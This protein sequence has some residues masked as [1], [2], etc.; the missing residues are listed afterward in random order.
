MTGLDYITQQRRHAAYKQK[1]TR[2]HIHAQACVSTTGRAGVLAA[3]WFSKTMER[4][5][6]LCTETST[7]TFIATAVSYLII[8]A[9]NDEGK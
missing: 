3:A 6:V 5:D 4:V 7:Y 1:H 8:L 9:G 2:Y